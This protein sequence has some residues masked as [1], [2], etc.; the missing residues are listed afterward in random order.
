MIQLPRF[1]QRLRG[2]NCHCSVSGD[3]AVEKVNRIFKG[4][5]LTE[6]PSHTIHYGH[7]VD[8]DTNQVIEEVM[9]S[10]MRAPRT[11][12]R[13]NIVEINCHGGL[14]SV[15]KV[16]QLILAQRSTISGTW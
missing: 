16:L 12:T 15:N 6:V 11:F 7:I 14:V 8:L 13:E 9:V 5:D 3:D 4:K 2:C 10:I 1:P